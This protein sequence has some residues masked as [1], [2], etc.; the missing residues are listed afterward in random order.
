M[1]ISRLPAGI[2]VITLI[3]V[4]LATL[5]PGQLKPLAASGEGLAAIILSYF[6]AAVGELKGYTHSVCKAAAAEHP[7]FPMCSLLRDAFG[8]G[9][10]G[11]VRAVFTQAPV[12][13]VFSLLQI[14]IHL[15]LILAAGKAMK[16]TR[17]DVLIASNANVGGRCNLKHPRACL[18]ISH[19]DPL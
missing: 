2:P 11:N 1:L 6:F 13:F 5:F 16:F 17:R 10:N 3:T 14:G 18:Q 4:L 8:A 12:L 7:R 9:A 15:V 19:A